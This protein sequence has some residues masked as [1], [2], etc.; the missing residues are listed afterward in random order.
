ME[1]LIKDDR[2]AH[3]RAVIKSNLISSGLTSEEIL[4]ITENLYRDIIDVLENFENVD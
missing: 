2:D 4:E 1:N 3:L